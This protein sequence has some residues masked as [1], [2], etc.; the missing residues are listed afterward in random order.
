MRRASPPT[1]LLLLPFSPL[2]RRAS[3][4][5]PEPASLSFAMPP[6]AARFNGRLWQHGAI[7]VY[8]DGRRVSKDYVVKKLTESILAVLLHACPPTPSQSKWAKLSGS[9][10]WFVKFNL[11]HG[12]LQQLI[13]V[14]YEKSTFLEEPAGGENLDPALAAQL[15]FHKVAGTR[16]K[17][18]LAMA[19]DVDEQ[20]AMLVLLIAVEPL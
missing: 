2:L 17:R 3:P 20:W 14:A 10:A 15:Q 12:A 8:L 7:E 5:S 4:P 9:L 13:P 1:A 18:L 11:C 6:A 16:Y 19:S